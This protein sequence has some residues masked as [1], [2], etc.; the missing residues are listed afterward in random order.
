ML[1]CRL[2]PDLTILARMDAD[3]ETPTDKAMRGAKVADLLS[4]IS[5]KRR[6]AGT[7]ASEVA[8]G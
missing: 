3:Q 7:L 1:D 8:K 2:V 4:D 6:A 5:R